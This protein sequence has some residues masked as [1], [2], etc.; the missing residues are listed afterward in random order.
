MD[1]TTSSRGR[2]LNT[3][4]TGDFRVAYSGCSIYFEQPEKP[5]QITWSRCWE[6]WPMWIFSLVLTKHIPKKTLWF[7]VPRIPSPFFFSFDDTPLSAT[8]SVWCLWDL[9]EIFSQILMKRPN[10]SKII[11]SIWS[12]SETRCISVELAR[13]CI[14]D[15]S[16]T[17][18][19]V[20]H[21]MPCT[22]ECVSFQ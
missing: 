7:H 2:N 9:P 15:T 21:L 17:R 11:C 6:T 13:V 4:P 18:I 3:L 19:D 14:G 1:L 5:I 22:Y 10:P 20:V 8:N 12:A 16:V